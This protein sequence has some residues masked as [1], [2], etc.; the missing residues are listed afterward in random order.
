M[1][2]GEKLRTG[3]NYSDFL[4]ELAF[5]DNKAFPKCYLLLN[6]C[7]ELKIRRDIEDNS[8]TIFLISQQKHML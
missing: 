2:F 8:K 6:I 5:L 4:Y 1:S 7:T 3:N